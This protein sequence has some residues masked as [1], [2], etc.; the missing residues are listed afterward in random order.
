MLYSASEMRD[1]IGVES[2]S[3]P[4]TIQLFLEDVNNK[5]VEDTA[6]IGDLIVSAA[7][8]GQSSII[9]KLKSNNAEF[10]QA[11]NNGIKRNLL[12]KGYCIDTMLSADDM[13]AMSISWL[14][15]N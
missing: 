11:V 1:L 9:I 14:S 3:S 4:T 7:R 15:Q 10:G 8:D 12:S 2:Q 6:K 5:I 13:V